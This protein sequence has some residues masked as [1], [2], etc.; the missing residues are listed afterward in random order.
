MPNRFKWLVGCVLVLALWQLWGCEQPEDVL[1]PANS[2]ELTLKAERLPTLPDGLVYELW[3]AKSFSTWNSSATSLGR[4]AYNSDRKVY[5]NPDGSNRA[6]KGKF[7]LDDDVLNYEVLMVT[8]EQSGTPST[9]PGPVMLWDTV[10]TFYQNPI[11]M[12]FPLSDSLWFTTA[13]FNMETPSDGGRDDNDGSGLWFTRYQERV[14]I[15]QDTLSLDS[16]TITTAELT[17][18][19]TF[20][21]YVDSIYNI[22]L[23]TVDTVFGF[24]DTLSRQVVRY[25][26]EVKID[27]TFPYTYNDN[28]DLE[29]TASDDV[30]SVI[31][32]DY[33]LLDTLFIDYSEYGWQYRGWVVSEAIDGCGATMNLPAWPVEVAGNFWIPGAKTG[34]M[35]STG[36]FV[37]VN[38]ADSGVDYSMSD[39]RPPYP[40]EDFFDTPCGA[41]P[42]QLVDGVSRGSC[43][44]TLEPMNFDSD[45]NFPLILLSSGLPQFQTRLQTTQDGL[46]VQEYYMDNW[47]RA[48][49]DGVY[50]FPSVFVEVNRLSQ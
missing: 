36:Y 22:R 42:L 10:T 41:G 26:A 19:T 5:L 21:T 8:V 1:V 23:D 14:G 50:G 18:D 44:I 43:M 45:A 20:T 4:F 17:E 40:G 46:V 38:S 15:S 33:L 12:R 37:D 47:S 11:R 13:M 7:L 27:S 32:G 34:E 6:D 35:L 16:W 29:Y 49:P 24:W 3:V 28:F 2:T 39:R 9:T 25:D 31:Y 30:D 48:T